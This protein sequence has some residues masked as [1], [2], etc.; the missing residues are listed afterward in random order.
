MKLLKTNTK[1]SLACG[2]TLIELLVVIAII[3]ILAAMLLPA[4]AKA[5]QKAQQIKCMNNS[6]Q[7]ALAVQM[8]TGDSSELYPPNPDDGNTVP[9]HNWCAAKVRGGMPDDPVPAGDHTF[10]SDVLGDDRSTLISAYVAKNVEVFRC[11]ADPRRDGLYDGSIFGHIGQLVPVSRSISMNQSVGTVCRAFLGPNLDGA[12]GSHSGAPD[13]SNSGPWLTGTHDQNKANNPWATFGRT[14]DFR[15][16]GASMVWLTADEDPYSIND[17]GLAVSCGQVKW[18][19]NFSTYH[20]WGCGLSFC[21]GHAEIHKWL[22][23]SLRWVNKSAGPPTMNT[24]TTSADYQ[25]W[26]WIQQRTSTR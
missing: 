10:D 3:A 2:F 25:D 16:M 13:Q 6:K 1:R 12:G 9:G 17:G 4:L 21:D 22:G 5:K 26:D 20:N 23:R 19:D 24:A 7:F 8:Y 18:V 11:P 14:S 15:K